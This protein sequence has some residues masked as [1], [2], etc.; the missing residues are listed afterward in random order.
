MVIKNPSLEL[1]D[2]FIDGRPISRAIFNNPE[3]IPDVLKYFGV[4]NRSARRT[5]VHALD[6]MATNYRIAVKKRAP[7]FGEAKSILDQFE[8]S[9][10]KVRKQWLHDLRPLHSII[11]A[12]RIATIPPSE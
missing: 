2:F 7:K 4:Q 6:M 1:S 10:R 11:I 5:I 3:H 8:T 9:L 12:H